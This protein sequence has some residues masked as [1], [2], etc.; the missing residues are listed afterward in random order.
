MSIPFPGPVPE[1]GALDTI[2]SV[3]YAYVTVDLRA[4]EC[5]ERFPDAKVTAIDM[6][7]LLPRLV[8]CRLSLS[9]TADDPFSSPVPSNF[10]FQQLDIL[11]GSLPWEAGSF[12]VVHVRFLL[13]HVRLRADLCRWALLTLLPRVASG[14]TARP[15]EHRQARQA[16][17]LASDRGGVGE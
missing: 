13:I 9:R 14:T 4:I 3:S 2:V 17:R 11:A 12:D 5:A 8:L 10:Q 15:R 16:R 7:P 6:N 1:Y